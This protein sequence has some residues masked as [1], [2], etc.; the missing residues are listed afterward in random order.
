MRGDGDM[1]MTA[2]QQHRAARADR[3]RPAE[4]HRRRHEART[5][6]RDAAGLGA[7][8]GSAGL[9]RQGHARARRRHAALLPTTTGAT[10]AGC[11]RATDTQARRRLRHL[12]PLRLRRRPAQLQVDQH[13]SDRRVWE[14]MHLAY[15]YGANR[16]WIVNVGDLKPMEFPISVLPRLRVESRRAWPAE[17]LPEYTRHWAAQQFGPEHAAEIADIVT[18]YAEVRR[19]AQARAARH[20]HVQPDELPRGGDASS[21]TYDSLRGRARARSPSRCRPSTHD[22]YYELV[23]HPVKAAANLNELYVT[24]ARNRLYALQGRA[25]TNDLADS[26]RATVRPGRRDLAATTT[27]SWPAASGTT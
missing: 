10:S 1:P 17:R 15:E 21:P 8:Q 4:D 25:A 13:E 3:R 14:Q 19:P 12:L 24:V 26:A 27:R 2:G 9:L 22:A 20:R 5:A 7:L 18:T 6:S 11:R 16:I 23:L